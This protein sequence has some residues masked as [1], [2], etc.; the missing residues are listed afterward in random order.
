MPI[1]SAAL[2]LEQNTALKTQTV[3]VC[4]SPSCETGAQHTPGLDGE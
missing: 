2:N 3:D 4:V 1:V